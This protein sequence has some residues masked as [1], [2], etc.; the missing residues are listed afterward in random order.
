M[1]LDSRVIAGALAHGLSPGAIATWDPR[2]ARTP[3]VLVP[4]ELDVLM[5]REEGGTWA[6]TAMTV[7]DPGS[8]PQAHTLLPDPFS[9]RAA[10]PAGAY[11]HWA[12][13]DALTGGSGTARGGDVSFPPVPDRWLVVRLSTPQPGARR[14]VT[15]WVLESG[16]QQP[17]VTALDSWTE[18][19]DP[20]RTTTPGEQPL[21]VLGHGDAAWSAYFDNVENRLA[22]YDDLTDGPGGTV[23]GPLAYLVC[24]WHSRHIDDPIGEGLSSPAAFEAR[25]AGLGWEINPADIEQAFSYADSRVTAATA[26]GLVTREA[27][28]SRVATAA[29][30]YT[31]V[32]AGYRDE[33][34]TTLQADQTPLLGRLGG[35][36]VS[37]P[38]LTLYHGGVVGIGWPGP[39]IGVA[40][41]GLTGGGIGGPPAADSVTVTIGNTLTEALAAR[42]AVNQDAP[43]EARVLE[44]VLLGGTQELDQPDAAARIDSLLHAS[45]FAGL[46][47]GTRT[48]DL[49]QRP[50]AP[51]AS[52]VP[53]PSRTDPG[54]FAGQSAGQ[55]ARA[56]HRGPPGSG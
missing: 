17:V 41:D 24:G 47:G 7:P 40:P 10:R 14:A 43:D 2:L 5:V 34:Q 55:P 15:A 31:V 56:R 28:F 9:E 46:P 35:R 49:A 39:G 1:A 23:A 29:T 6:Q 44:A 3:R 52:V 20:E 50:A 32:P 13:P 48:E 54:V 11:L 19:E 18:P 4:V 36:A 30:G 22:F 53:D 27:T 51:P 16:G 12:L 38:E 37:W 21:T 45:G 33:G 26:A 8:Q 42:L 25:L